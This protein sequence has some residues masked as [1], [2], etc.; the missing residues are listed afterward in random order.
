MKCGGGEVTRGRDRPTIMWVSGDVYRTCSPPPA[1]LISLPSQP[2]F[3]DPLL[4][5][6]VAKSAGSRHVCSPIPTHVSCD[7]RKRS[8]RVQAD[9][10][11]Q[12]WACAA[13]WREGRA[14]GRRDVRRLARQVANRHLEHRRDVEDEA[15]G[16]CHKVEHPEAAPHIQPHRH[17]PNPSSVTVSCPPSQP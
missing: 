16:C 13:R 7:W 10:P 1:P 6:P 17:S 3:S 9:T 14:A 4:T 15:H 12:A 5:Q 11:D 8:R 2:P